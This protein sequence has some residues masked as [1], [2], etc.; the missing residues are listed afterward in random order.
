MKI[1]NKILLAIWTVVVLIGMIFIFRT[2][3]DEAIAK[4]E[5]VNPVNDKIMYEFPEIPWYE[6]G[7][8]S[9]DEYWKDISSKRDEVRGIADEAIESY[10]SVITEEQ[11]QALRDYEKKMLNAIYVDDFEAALEEFNNITDE[12]QSKMRPV[13]SY[14]G[15]SS[16]SGGGFDIPYNFKQMGV[17]YDSRYRYTYYSSKVLYHYR[18]PEWMLGS[19][20]IY[21]DANGRVVVASDDYPQGTVVYSELFGECV[22]LDCGVGTSGTLDVYVGW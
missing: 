2:V 20:G 15:P 16:Y 12:C 9:L 7:Y 4:E 6:M 3:E 11:K 14:S 1:D 13:R 10:S 21:R 8:S 19:D 5:F 22:V 17:L 18:T